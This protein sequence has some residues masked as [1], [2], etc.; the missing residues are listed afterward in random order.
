MYDMYEK[1]NAHLPEQSPVDEER[2]SSLKKELLA[3]LTIART[4]EDLAVIKR[5][6]LSCDERTGN[7]ME[8]H[9]AI[10]KQF[11]TLLIDEVKKLP[12]E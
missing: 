2:E 10:I 4:L 8:I 5:G 1:I 11:E 6:S 9:N 7:R 3:Q 12:K